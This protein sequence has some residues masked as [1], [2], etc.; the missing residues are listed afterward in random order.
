MRWSALLGMCLIL[1]LA[2]ALR[3]LGA[4][5]GNP[6]P[7][8]AP[9]TAP[10]N[11][12]HEQTP[13]HPDEFL[14]VTHALM[15]LRGGSVR[16]G[17]YENP[18]FLINLNY[19]TYALTNSGGDLSPETWR[20]E[21]QR[22]I[23]PF[24]LYFMARVYSALGGLL[25]VAAAY[26]MVQRLSSRFAAAASALLAA[27]AFPLVQHAHYGTTSSLA[28]GFIAVS[29]FF[30]LLAM[31]SQRRSGRWLLLAALLAGL[32]TGSRYN[33]GLV[34]LFVLLAGLYVLRTRRQR[35]WHVLLAFAAFPLTFLLTTPYV[36]LHT[37]EFLND[38]RYISN[39]YLGTGGVSP[40]LGLAYEM[41]YLLV[42]GIGIPA[43]LLLIVA[44]GRA[45][46]RGWW[47]AI[48]LPEHSFFLFLLLYALAYSL[49]VLRTVRPTIADQLLLPLLPAAIVL[50]GVGA[51]RLAERWQGLLGWTGRG[52]LLVLLVIMPLAQGVQFVGRLLQEDTREMMQAWVY[53]QIPRGASVLLIGPYNVALDAAD[54][55]WRQQ[56]TTVAQAA[57]EAWIGVDYLLIS[58]ANLQKRSLPPN[59]RYS[60]DENE[61]ARLAEVPG[62]D[63]GHVQLLHEV[64]RPALWGTDW[65]LH[66]ATYWH[67][68]GLRLYCLHE[69]AC[70]AAR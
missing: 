28:A 22:R 69:A 38:I 24:R 48:R 6:N 63:L 12:L 43:G 40:W 68:P 26:G 31:R 67:N 2:F 49:L 32:A 55:R 13:L 46:H 4:S 35:L 25:V 53:A 61:I 50:A 14:F 47:R 36:L 17:F 59:P 64:E 9:S 37:Q 10:H 1:L 15:M 70:A 44:L 57:E 18:S 3:I 29:A 65:A 5:F 66:S 21:S 23:A 54:Y 42:F 56:F 33:A 41:R 16:H 27:A 8:Y 60:G 58:D 19:V 39:Q 30:A 45:L 20:Q 34:G 11:L 52:L 51:G 62:I 7:A